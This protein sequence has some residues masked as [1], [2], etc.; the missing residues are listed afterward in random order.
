MV[1]STGRIVAVT[2]DHFEVNECQ[3]L[4]N[5][6]LPWVVYSNDGGLTW[7]PDSSEHPSLVAEGSAISPSQD[8]DT[9]FWIDRNKCAPAIAVDRATDNVYVAFYARSSPSQS[10][11]DIYISRSPNEGESFPSDTANLVQLT[12]LM[13]TGVPGDGVGPDQVMPSIAIDDCGGVNLVFYD[14]RHD[15]DRGDQNPY[16]DV[17]FV[18]ISNYGTGNQSIQQFRLTPRSFL[19]TQQGAFLG[20]YHHLASAPPTP[21]VPMV[22]L[23]PTYITPDGL[24]R[25][26]YM[27]R[28]QVVCG[29]ES[30][31]ALSD[32]DRD[33]VVQEKDV[34]AF[35]EAYQ[36]GDCAADLD[37]DDEV[38]EFDAQIFTEVYSAAAD[39][40]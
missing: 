32:V 11:A 18:R 21:T 2:H 5:G 23:Y 31:L 14:N 25:S 4:Y 36:L 38:S 33:G 34:H 16:Y 7:L 12:D 29:G 26:C 1:L 8:A 28:I 17:Y 37:G 40:P 27:H 6:G 9:P 13:L 15:P 10:N 35:E 20:D 24:N 39:G 19:P 22:P 3:G 30:L